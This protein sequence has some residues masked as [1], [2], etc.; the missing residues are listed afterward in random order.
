MSRHLSSGDAEL[1]NIWR[2]FIKGKT[3][4]SGRARP[5]VIDGWLRS[6]HFGVDPFMLKAPVVLNRETL[7]EEI[8]RK[9]SLLAVALPVIYS[10]Y[11]IVRESGFGVGITNED[12]III[13]CTVDEHAREET[14]RAGMVEGALWTEQS[15][16]C[17]AI[18][19]CLA[20]KR[21]VQIV[22]AEHFCQSWHDAACSAAPIMD[23]EGGLIG[24]LNMIVREKDVNPTIL[25]MVVAGAS[26]IQREFHLQTVHREL[27]LSHQYLLE[28]MESLPSGIVV[29]NP[30]GIIKKINRR[31]C[32][33]LKSPGNELCGRSLSNVIGQ[34][35]CIERVLNY[36][37]GQEETEY[38][39]EHGR[40]R[41]HFTICCRP[42]MNIEG[43]M[44]GA[45]V[46]IREIDAVRRMTTKMAGYKAKFTFNDIVGDSPAI[47]HTLEAAR[48][49]AATSSVVLITGESG[50]GKEMFAQ[51]IHNASH[52]RNGPFVAIN[53]GALPRELIGSELFGYEEGAFTGARKG[54]SPGKFELASNGTL[55][56]DEIGEM[57]VDLQPALLRVLQEKTLVRLGGQQEIGVN[58]RLIAATSRD[59]RQ[60]VDRGLFRKDLFYRLDVIKLP[61]PPL[62]ERS[63]DI[64]LLA[65]HYLKILGEKLGKETRGISPEAREMLQSYSWPG[66]IR[67]LEN[68]LERILVFSNGPVLRAD[69]L[70]NELIKTSEE[71]NGQIED[72]INEKK[73]FHRFP[74]RFERKHLVET[75]YTND[76]NITQTAKSLGVTRATLYRWLKHYRIEITRRCEFEK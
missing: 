22:G 33:M 47:R 73:D 3:I 27:T 58:V 75:L 29:I 54:G 15:V 7:A 31:A 32:E 2:D 68:M 64:L 61:L 37:K 45:V 66:N 41:F 34:V 4:R 71:E 16:G 35:D 74:Y 14:D 8:E 60:M 5:E 17:N 55:F 38:Y 6:Q 53:C 52:R 48:S 23:I 19:T 72:S 56:L 62:R 59:L 18:G 65:N 76:G 9:K 40:H 13:N 50:T 36:G 24:V 46:I 49:A 21:P 44:D 43:G 42:I 69:W 20:L 12:G 11:S 25:G 28:I 67:E 1:K 51:A 63:E 30:R 10:L 39:T 26:A 57:P 70:P